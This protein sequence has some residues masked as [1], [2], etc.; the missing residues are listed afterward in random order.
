[1]MFDGETSRWMMRSGRPRESTAECAACSAAPTSAQIYAACSGG[2]GFFF[3]RQR[4]R[5]VR[6]SLPSTC[7]IAMKYSPCARA[8][9]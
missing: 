7:S 3:A 1:M 2:I 9:S 4:S 8:N 6:M 5:T